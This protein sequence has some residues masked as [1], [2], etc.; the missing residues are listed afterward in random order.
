MS[1]EVK[2]IDLGEV[3]ADGEDSP[4]EANVADIV[5]LAEA[6]NYIK[7]QYGTLTVEDNLLSDMIQAARQWI[8]QYIRKSIIQKTI[9]AYTPDEL[10]CFNLPM[11]PVQEISTVK[12]V[13]IEGTKTELT[14][15]TDYYVTGQEDKTLY[16]YT[17]WGTIS[18]GSTAGLEV[19]YTSNYV[20]VPKALKN[21][22]LKL[23]AENYYNRKETNDE[24]ITLVPFDVRTL[25]KPYRKF[26]L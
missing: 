5:T 20:E 16:F 13:D 23:V 15:N 22:C 19:T 1:V 26:I 10:A 12:R 4:G 3:M 17:V 25:C 7:Q 21:A 18:G 9:I 6:K 11:G 24:G 2:I 14:L 8:E